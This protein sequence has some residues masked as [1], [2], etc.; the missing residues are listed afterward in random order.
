MLFYLNYLIHL[1]FFFFAWKLLVKFFKAML[2]NCRRGR[3]RL[4]SQPAQ[5]SHHRAPLLWTVTFQ[6][7]QQQLIKRSIQ[8]KSEASRATAGRKSAPASSELLEEK[9][10]LTG[11]STFQKTLLSGDKVSQYGVECAVDRASAR[12]QMSQW[13]K[14]D[15]PT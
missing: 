5:P 6:V 9:Y 8:K 13:L 10:F 12:L 4:Y 2:D 11:V 15:A 14:M 7:K 1:S 3:F